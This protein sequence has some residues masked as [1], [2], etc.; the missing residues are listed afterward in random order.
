MFVDNKEGENIAPECGTQDNYCGPSRATD[1]R[2]PC[3]THADKKAA[4]D[5][6]LNYNLP[7][8]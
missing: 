2:I 8:K 4:S 7:D 5:P 1:P 6:P 3:G